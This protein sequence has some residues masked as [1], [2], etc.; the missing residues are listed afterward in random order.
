MTWFEEFS[1]E[2][3]HQGGR[4]HASVRTIYCVSEG[5]GSPVKLGIA[6][7]LSTRISALNCGNWRELRLHW[8]APG[9]G[10]HE[11]A[12]NHL[13]QRFA[14]RGEWVS[15]SDDYLKSALTPTA[16]TDD[17]ETLIAGLAATQKGLPMKWQ[18]KNAMPPD[19]A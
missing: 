3:S 19:A 6:T 12:L 8:S 18:H 15:D 17:L 10:V 9:T 1:S 14:I 4:H 2:F 11:Y 5:A 7:R 16:T 13:L